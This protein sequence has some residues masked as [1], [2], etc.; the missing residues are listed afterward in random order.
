MTKWAFIPWMQ[1]FFNIRKSINV[2]HHINK[3]KNKI[4]MIISIDAEKVLDKIQ[5]PFMIKKKKLYRK[6]A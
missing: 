3:L 4:H 6:Q 5:Y 1:G 2:I